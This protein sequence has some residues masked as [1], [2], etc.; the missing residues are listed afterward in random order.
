[1]K[2]DVLMV[3]YA[4]YSSDARI[5][6]YVY[7]LEKAGLKYKIWALKERNNENPNVEFVMK[8]YQGDKNLLY[9]FTYI[10]FFFKLFLKALKLIGRVG[11]I[12]YHN[13]PNFIVFAFFLNRLFGAKLILDLHDDMPITYMTKFN[14][15]KDSILF[16]FLRW[17][18]LF[19]SRHSDYIIT[20]IHYLEND[21][22]ENK[23]INSKI[24]TIINI[25]NPLLFKYNTKEKVANDN[26]TIVTHGVITKRLGLDLAL[27]ALYFLKEKRQNIKLV[28]I[29]DG[30]YKDELYKLV[31][32]LGLL[33]M[34]EFSEGF[35]KVEDL[36]KYLE[37]ADIGIIPYRKNYY[38]NYCQLPVKLLEYV[39]LG[40]PVIAPSFENIKRYFSNSMIKYF[41]PDNE[42]DFADK[43]IELYDSKD[44]RMSFSKNAKSFYDIYTWE[45]QEKLYLNIINNLKSNR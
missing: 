8:K 39:Y 3:G 22:I 4:L 32:E 24:S 33:N 9:L 2:I 29:G 23:I 44:E 26:F 25:P 30:D 43:I 13:M 10:Y 34:V 18:H 11:V 31:N 7:S 16:R 20:A 14:I 42:V 27:R 45:N 40:I 36:G 41:E 15:K 38:S 1:M 21:L 37:K 12:H 35:I 19:S 17:E 6:S 5:K 28:I